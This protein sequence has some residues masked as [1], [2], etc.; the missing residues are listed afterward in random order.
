M[1]P[2]LNNTS[3]SE[4]L[5]RLAVDQ[6]RL[7]KVDE[8]E[9]LYREVVDMAPDHGAASHNLGLIAFRRNDVDQ[10]LSLYR[11]ATVAKPGK[12][13]FWRSYIDALIATNRFADAKLALADARA[14][15]HSS[16]AFDALDERIRG[17]LDQAA[18][19]AAAVG[20]QSDANAYVAPLLDLFNR[21]NFADAETLARN[22]VSE[23]PN[24]GFGWKLLGVA[25][26]MLGV[27]A[28]LSMRRA[29]ELL[30]EDPDTHLNLGAAL[31]TSGDLSG[32][33]VA[34]RQA[35]A[36][37]PDIAEAH[38]NLGSVL[39]RK[40]L[41]QEASA[42]YEVAARL[43]PNDQSSQLR[44]AN[45]CRAAHDFEKA[46]SAYRRA[47]AIAALPSDALLGFALTLSDSGAA[48]AAFEYF[49]ATLAASGGDAETHRLFGDA[50]MAGNRLDEAE[51]EYR[52][53]LLFKPDLFSAQLNLGTCLDRQCKREDAL[54]AFRR[55]SQIDP[56]SPLAHA[57][58]SA[59]LYRLGR[60][61]EAV[62][63]A[64]QA[65][66]NDP[67]LPSAYLNLGSALQALLEYPAA[68]LA[69][70]EALRLRPDYA[71]A[72]R[73]IGEVLL[74]YGEVDGA[75]RHYRRA[76]ELGDD[77]ASLVQSLIFA[78]HYLPETEQLAAHRAAVQRYAEKIRATATPFRDWP[79]TNRAQ[80]KLRVGLISGDFHQ[81]PVGIFCEG[82]IRE[83]DAPDIELFAYYNEH[84][85][86]DLNA[87]LR[88]LFSQWR[89]IENLP[90]PELAALI[91]ADEIDILV[92]MAG[93]C[94]RNSLSV[95]A[96]RP[97]PVQAT[98]LGYFATTG[99]AEIDYF[100]TDS[101]VLPEYAE[102]ELIERPKRLPDSF[103]CLA[104]PSE[105]ID[106]APPPLERSDHFTF[107]C[108]NYSTKV[109]DAVIA[110]WS[111]ILAAVP[112]SKLFLKSRQLAFAPAVD[113][114][115]AGFSKHGIEKE[116]LIIEAASPS[117]QYY[118]AYNRVDL[119]LDPF[120]YTGGTTSVDALWM[121][122]PVLTLHS[123]LLIGRQGESILQTVGLP[124][125]VARSQDEYAA[126]AIAL[127]NDSQPLRDLRST[128]RERLLASPLCD[129]RKYGD[130]LANLFREMWQ[131]RGQRR[132]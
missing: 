23:H 16:A 80:W 91:R 42:S 77:S 56:L 47:E 72:C 120:P 75:I 76:I 116:R 58:Q 84:R 6:H 43:A 63:A 111:T 115:V 93:H 92:D 38:T 68:M 104:P 110:L 70:N 95:F 124:E 49:R 71:N 48:E 86:D 11:S 78:Q 18:S 5:F 39:E 15:G 128:L 66:N 52:N 100:I 45:A 59:S 73:N 118:E 31:L 88:P 103:L 130:A 17:L 9:R 67:N 37:D 8:A 107:G 28:I 57:N 36:I 1:N 2:Q 7:G 132:D 94:A 87:R 101:R 54:R 108:F 4:D 51:L 24:F 60:Y 20:G 65:I 96:L 129:S 55:A 26:Q 50:L 34:L 81:H 33:E 41:M 79:R 113:R 98:W 69:F 114:I 105:E 112:A 126:R 83:F 85:R 29:A 89:D 44:H 25:Q 53:A 21:S 19:A 32:A 30:P 14:A 13:Q 109:N 127:A 131:E 122:V 3:R 119:C 125:F 40:G 12:E 61:E 99:L 123:D 46:I 27:P 62:A 22:A 64:Q 74:E 106:I 82:A 117:R 10:A 97:A 121:G 90:D 35:I 102:G